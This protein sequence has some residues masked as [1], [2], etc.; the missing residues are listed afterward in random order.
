M[1]SEIICK[2]YNV[3][4]ENKKNKKTWTNSTNVII[5]IKWILA[6]PDVIISRMKFTNLQIL[7][8]NESLFLGFLETFQ[9]IVE[10]KIVF[11]AREHFIVYEIQM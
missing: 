6:L 2:V 11:D 5:W 8:E 3:K 10:L 1:K 4:L 7:I 9:R